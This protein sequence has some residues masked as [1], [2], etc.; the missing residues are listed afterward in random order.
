M[1]TVSSLV[2][3]VGAAFDWID[4]TVFVLVRLRRRRRRNG[5]SLVA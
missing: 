4:L 5:S 2:L 1:D 3:I